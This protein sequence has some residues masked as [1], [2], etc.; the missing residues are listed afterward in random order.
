[1]TLCYM[2]DVKCIMWFF[3]KNIITC[4]LPAKEKVLSVL[5]FF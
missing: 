4:L 3:K 5:L 1:M 2:S